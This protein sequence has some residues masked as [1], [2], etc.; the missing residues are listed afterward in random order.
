MKHEVY[1][2]DETARI[3]CERCGIH[4]YVTVS[5]FG[6]NLARQS[7]STYIC[8]DCRAQTKEQGKK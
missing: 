8:R 5:A 2:E 1:I 3:G 7:P 6:K 4:F